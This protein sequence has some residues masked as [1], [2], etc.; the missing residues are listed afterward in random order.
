MNLS[1]VTTLQS[2]LALFMPRVR[3]ARLCLDIYRNPE[4]GPKSEQFQVTEAGK[5][6]LSGLRLV[7]ILVVNLLAPGFHAALA[8]LLVQPQSQ[9]YLCNK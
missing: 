2:D 5:E 8:W 3:R 9:S 6:Q 7:H 1:D 4:P